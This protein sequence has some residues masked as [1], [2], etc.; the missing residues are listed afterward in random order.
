M[1]LGETLEIIMEKN[2]S[3][4]GLS[5]GVK[6]IPLPYAYFKERM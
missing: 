1:T 6:N 2:I 3:F 4:M 5:W